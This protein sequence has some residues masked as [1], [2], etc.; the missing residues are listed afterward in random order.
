MI[1]R[2]THITALLLLLI[3]GSLAWAGSAE[4]SAQTADQELV[5][6]STQF[7]DFAAN[8]VQQLNHNHVLSRA[9]MQVTKQ[10]DGSYKG[11][12]H[13]IDENSMAVKVRRSSSSSIPFVGIISYQEQVFEG[14]APTLAQ[15][16]NRKF[17]LVQIIPNKHLFSYK[18]GNWQ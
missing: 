13:Q 1:I 10:P 14:H 18:K 11:I 15:L 6:K 7:H 5:E 2:L 8:K 4:S 9:R 16:G 17:D 12:Y 3:F